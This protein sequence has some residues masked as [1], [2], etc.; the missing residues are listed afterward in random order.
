VPYDEAVEEA[1]CYGWIDSIVKSID[2]EKYAQKFTPRKPTSKWSPSNIERVKNMIAAGKMTPAGLAAF[3]GH[4]TR[5]IEP[6]PATLPGDLEVTFK[7]HKTAWNN[8]VAFPPGY[9]RM[10]MV[11]VASAKRPETQRK[12]LETLI[13]TSERNERIKFM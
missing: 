6:H 9:R 12:R 1:L 10:M 2:D 13:E 5:M 4:E 3:E 7:S 8:F 11:W